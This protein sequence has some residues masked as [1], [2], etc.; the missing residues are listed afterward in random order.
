MD[1]EIQ[2]ISEG[3]GPAVIGS[4]TVVERFLASAGLSG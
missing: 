4:P 1:G 2:L 3:D